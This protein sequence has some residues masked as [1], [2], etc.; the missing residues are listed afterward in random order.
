M[1]GKTTI[2]GMNDT[3]IA[4][5]PKVCN[6]CSISQFRPIGLCNVNYKILSKALAQR[7]KPLMNILVG[8]EQSGFVPNR[9]II[10]NV[11]IVQELIHFMNTKLGRKGCCVIKV[12]LEKAYDRLNWNFIK[13][14]LTLA[15]L[16]FDIIRLIMDYI[17]FASFRVI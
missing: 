1:E 17:S 15:G 3:F 7:I 13:D 11:V 12:D 6:P 5:I 10:N 2:S 4:L 9:Q 8:E 16:P 14:T